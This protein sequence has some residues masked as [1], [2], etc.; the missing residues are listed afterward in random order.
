MRCSVCQRRSPHIS[1][2]IGVCGSCLTKPSRALLRRLARIH[3]N[4]RTDFSLPAGPP[5]RSRGVTCPLCANECSIG[6]NER[7][8]CGLRTVRSGRLV[9][10]AGTPDRGLL[11]WYRDPIPTNCVANWVCEGSQQPGYHNLAVFYA[12]CTADCLFCQNWYFREIPPEDEGTT[13]AIELAEAANPATFCVCFFGGDPTSQMPHALAA[14]RHLS[15]RGVR[16]CWETNGMMHPKF[17]DAAF[18]ISLQTGGCMKFDLKAF[19]EKLHLALTGVSN[20]RTLQNFASAARR[21]RQRSDPPVLVASTPLIPGY[22]EAE[23]VRKIAGFI[24]CFDQSIPY[25]L[26]AFGPHF[27]MSDLPPTSPQLAREAEQAAHDAGLINVH[28][29]NRHLLEVE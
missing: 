25:A 24:A 17:L 28:V 15:R 14:S 18:R 29:G 21:F 10:L 8:F 22:V 20:R 5:H 23:Q 27:Q 7:G 11:Q 1:R 6:E 13:S 26:L 3:A 9:H 2:A 16:I 4:C 12:S 19:D